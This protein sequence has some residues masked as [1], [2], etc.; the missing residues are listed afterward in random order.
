MLSNMGFLFRLAGV[1]KSKSIKQ[2]LSLD[3]YNILILVCNDFPNMLL[4]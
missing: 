1:I 3:A 2:T 4:D